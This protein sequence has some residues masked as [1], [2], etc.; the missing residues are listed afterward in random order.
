MIKEAL[1]LDGMVIIVHRS[2][3]STS[4]ANKLALKNWQEKLINYAKLNGTKE[5][6]MSIQILKK[7]LKS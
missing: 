5:L 3:K 7:R 1:W 2:S 4:G 6:N